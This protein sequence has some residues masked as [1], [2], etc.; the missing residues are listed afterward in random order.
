MNSAWS[1]ENLN[2]KCVRDPYTGPTVSPKS[3]EFGDTHNRRPGTAALDNSE[4]E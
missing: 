3:G 1:L 2:G 4:L